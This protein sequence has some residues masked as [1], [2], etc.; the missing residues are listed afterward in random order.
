MEANIM[1][2]L[3]GANGNITSKIAHILLSQGK[4][5]RIVGR[6]ANRLEALRQAGAETAVGDIADSAF[7]ASAMQA[8]QAVY[9]M[10]P[11]N[12]QAMAPLEG[13]TQM[14]KAIAQA[15][16]A[17][18]VRCVVNLS[19]IGAHLSTGTGPIVSLHA[20]EQRLD[21][22]KGVKT[23]H[24]R[25]GYFF[26]NHFNAIG[27]IAAH[28]VYSDMIDPQVPLPSLATQDIAMVAAR[29]LIE[30]SSNAEK[31][32]L[33]LR[34]PQFYTQTEAAAILGRAI[35]KPD[36]QYVQADPE[37][38]KAGMVQAGISPAMAELLIEMNQTFVKP[39][40]VAEMIAGPTEITPTRLEQL[41]PNFKAAYENTITI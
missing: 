10:V 13:Y 14:G 39:E 15:I 37:Q 20:Q 2:V 33:H 30:P 16:L 19:S 23:L 21:Q 41:A 1:Y 27:L 29:E 6:N 38:A 28:G 32:V 25:P 9:T 40:F 4:K 35:G 34:G 7:L 31:Q 5:V 18:E 36:L 11:P 26:E 8:A 3:L 17:A 22:I 24:L 12:Y